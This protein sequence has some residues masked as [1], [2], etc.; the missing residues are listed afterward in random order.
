[1]AIVAAAAMLVATA[2]AIA[3][4]ATT[5]TLPH[6]STA[7]ARGSQIVVNGATRAT[8]RIA[9]TKVIGAKEISEAVLEVM[10]RDLTQST[11]FH[12]LDAKEIHVN[13]DAEGLGIDPKAWRA[14]GAEGIVKAQSSVR[15]G[16]I[17]LDLRLYLVARGTEPVL[18]REL[19]VAPGA[20]RAALHQW[21]NDVVKAFTQVAGSFGTYLVFGTTLARGE[22]AIWQ[23]GADGE[24]LQRLSAAATSPIAPA[25]GQGS[26]YYAGA[27]ADGVHALFRIGNPVAVLRQAGEIFGVAFG[28]GK[29]A[30]VVARDGQSDIYVGNPDGTG[31]TKATSGGLNTHPSLGPA[32][33]LAYASNRGGNPQIYV[34]GRRASARGTYNMAPTWCAAPEGARVVFMGRDGATWDIFSTDASGSIDAMQRLTQDQG[35]NTYPACSPDGRIVAFFSTRDAG[36]LYTS[37]IRGQNQRRLSTATGESLRWESF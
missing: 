36:G 7:S 8:F 16:T 12:V 4:S 1:M 2:P 3:D 35:S 14:D 5:A 22:K 20:L 23:I 24:G 13:V 34:D 29:M 15:G 10:T 37:D 30:L 21:D 33:Q 26:V 25:F 17:H 9:I 19:D 11:L 32:G 31:L 27:G 18:R 6:A 28:G